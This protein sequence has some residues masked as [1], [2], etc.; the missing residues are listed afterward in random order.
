MHV[1]DRGRLWITTGAGLV[2]LAEDNGPPRIFGPR[3]GLTDRQLFQVLTDGRGFVWVGSSRGILRLSE[4]DLDEVAAGRRPR[5]HFLS[6]DTSDRRRDVMATNIRQP[7]ATRD[8]E[9]RLWFATE[10][11]ALMI[12]P[13]RLRVNDRPPTVRIENAFADG[14][15]VLRGRDN[16]LPP[17]PGNLAFRFSAVTLLEPH[18]GLHRYMLEGFDAGWIEAGSRREAYYTNIPPGRYRF[19]V[20]GSNAD[21]LWNQEGDVLPFHLRPHFYRT[22]WFYA[23]LAGLACAGVTLLWR[24]RVRS[25][26]R[27]YLAAFTERSRVAR[28]LHD[29]LLQGMSAVGLQLRGLR[30][31]LSRE[32]P[33]PRASWRCWKGPSPAACRRPA[34]S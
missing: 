21:G 11:G 23:L 8:S 19:R 31:R 17:G 26:R 18:K 27:Q 3:Q 1:D 13:R 4:H 28:E 24:L 33:T 7:G 9:G 12:D 22:P 15:P 14:R 32:A 2:Q 29:T 30:R 25:L 6:L 34:A 5:L 16:Q 10:Q 20:Q